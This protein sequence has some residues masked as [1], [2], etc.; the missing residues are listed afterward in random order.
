MEDAHSVDYNATVQLPWVEKYRPANLRQIKGQ[1]H[2]LALLKPMLGSDRNSTDRF[3][4]LPHLLFH[5]PCGTGK[6]STIFAFA[7]HLYGPDQLEDHVLKLNTSDDLSLDALRGI[8]DPFAS[9]QPMFDC[10]DPPAGDDQGQSQGHPCSTRDNRDATPAEPRPPGRIPKL[11]ILDEVDEMPADTQKALTRLMEV[12]LK[13]VRFCLLCNDKGT[14]QPPLVSRCLAVPFP[15][16]PKSV[17]LDAIQTIARHEQVQVSEPALHAIV[18]ASDTPG[19][20]RSAINLLQAC[21]MTSRGSVITAEVVGV[22]SGHPPRSAIRALLTDLKDPLRIPLR[23]LP[24]VLESQ[25]LSG[26]PLRDL[27]TALHAELAEVAM[28]RAKTRPSHTGTNPTVG[29][30]LLSE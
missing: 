7:K 29:V 2:V 20:L 8:I 28:E 30:T 15:P 24:L 9:V 19:D 5:G 25:G 22:T 27:V 23:E 13:D 21:H 18:E 14:L 17:L 12:R 3:N 16:L 26:Y 4:A 11:I 6:T 10:P 1:E